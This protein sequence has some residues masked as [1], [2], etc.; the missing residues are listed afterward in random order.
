MRQLL[1]RQGVMR[2]LAAIVLLLAFA[3]NFWH[4]DGWEDNQGPG[5][6]P[7]YVDSA[8][9]YWHQGDRPGAITWS[10]GYVQLMSPF[11]G[12]LGKE[13]GYKVWRFVLF[14]AVT[15]SVF[16]VFAQITGSLWIGSVLAFF[17][18]LMLMPYQAPSLQMVV[19]LI[20][21]F[22]LW[23][24]AARA[25]YMG[26]VFALLLNGIY[27]SGT[28]SFVLLAFAV[29][30][31]LFHRETI[32][33]WRFLFQSAL[34]VALFAAVLQHFSYDIRLYP[35]EAADRGR[36]G[37]HHQLAE[38][39]MKSG[40]VTPYLTP[41]EADPAREYPS[42]Y[43]RH[44]NAF[45]RYY[46]EK[47]GETQGEVRAYRHDPRWPQFML[48]WPWLIE[49]QPALMQGYAVDVLRTLGRSLLGSFQVV[50][51]FAPYSLDDYKSEDWASF[52]YLAVFNIG[53]VILL[54][55]ALASPHWVARKYKRGEPA[56]PT[57]PSR[58]QWLFL[59]STLSAL[60]PLLLVKPLPI[61]FPPFIP[62][63]LTALM[64]VAS[65]LSRGLAKPR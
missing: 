6:D 63:Y 24:V 60:V 47:F 65:A 61:Y 52:I 15:L 58:L 57:R 8:Y 37:F 5:D 38:Y 51:P 35:I 43:E 27:I 2:L 23:L 32:F 40:R 34:G 12:L 26:L 54:I 41:E 39:L 7:I 46:L 49:K 11:V 55:L 3:F 4:V 64:L 44:Q 14:S 19:C 16:G 45:D 53:A 10:P 17:S 59:L 62:A 28:L 18:Q 48:D 31:L 50:N 36:A 33:T 25:K 42:E 1:I 29:F 20:Y 30:C 22:C 21:L 13:P 9:T 56:L